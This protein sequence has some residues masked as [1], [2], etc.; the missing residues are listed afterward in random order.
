[1]AASEQQSEKLNPTTD[2]A[3]IEKAR[4]LLNS[5]AD[6]YVEDS[7]QEKK[8]EEILDQ[9]RNSRQEV[10]SE[11]TNNSP[12][13]ISATLDQFLALDQQS[14]LQSISGLKN[15]DLKINAAFS[16][17]FKGNAPLEKA[18]GLSMIMPIDIRAVK[19]NGE[20]G[21]RHGSLGN[22]YTE[23]G[24][25]LKILTGDQVE[26]SEVTTAE[27]N[28]QLRQEKITKI[29]EFGRLLIKVDLPDDEKKLIVE[30]AANY[31]L[32]PR[33]FL[34][35]K[36]TFPNAFGHDTAGTSSTE[37]KISG[38]YLQ[39]ALIKFSKE[40][41]GASITQ[42]YSPEAVAYMINHYSLFANETPQNQTQLPDLLNNYGRLIGKVLK[43]PDN[44]VISN[45]SPTI[46]ATFSTSP[47]LSKSSPEKSYDASPKFSNSNLQLD[48][49]ATQLPADQ[50]SNRP[51]KKFESIRQ[52]HSENLSKLKILEK[53]RPALEKFR[54][55]VLA[56][57]ARY[58]QVAAQTGVPWKLIAALHNRESGMQFDT[59]LHNGQKLGK[60]TTAV[61]VGKLFYDWETAAIDALQTKRNNI[62]QNSD[63]AD[64]LAYAESYNG[65]GYRRPNFGPSGYVYAGTNIYQ[66]GKYVKDGVYDPNHYDQQLGVAAM[67]M[68]LNKD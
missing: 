49:S 68:A 3:R 64:Q 18:V 33:L 14:Q 1:M 56:N 17:D 54:Q 34:A 52:D 22:F 30:T 48:Y 57:R 16:C 55:K 20:Q 50:I 37:I 24:Q 5:A 10:K 15:A 60:P 66:G 26:I 65:L 58:E 8:R 32:D 6:L 9:S 11:I 12:E 53:I 43:T 38:K 67:L 2:P 45:S 46:P 41:P 39:S 28:K 63:L 47:T 36:Q 4:K 59:Y 19:V 7:D 35:I 61:P 21:F 51:I 23:S 25:Y 42:P 31:D 27:Q 13:K 40:N 44:I 29:S 62:S